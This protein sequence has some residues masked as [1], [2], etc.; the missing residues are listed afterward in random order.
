MAQPRYLPDTNIGISIRRQRPQAVMDFCSAIRPDLAA[1]RELIGN[2][3]FD[4][5]LTQRAQ[6]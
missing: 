5:Q 6:G 4:W 1:Q 3:D 2:N